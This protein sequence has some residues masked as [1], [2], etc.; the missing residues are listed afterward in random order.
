MVTDSLI[1]SHT[2]LPCFLCSIYWPFYSSESPAVFLIQ[3]LC[4]YPSLASPQILL[5]W[6]PSDLTAVYFFQKPFFGHF[7]L[8]LHNF[9]SLS[10]SLCFVR[11]STVWNYC[12]EFQFFRVYFL[13]LKWSIRT[14]MLTSI[15][16]SYTVYLWHLQECMTSSRCL[17]W[18]MASLGCRTRFAPWK[19]PKGCKGVPRNR[20]SISEKPSDRPTQRKDVSCQKW[21][22]CTLRVLT[23]PPRVWNQW[24][25]HLFSTLPHKEVTTLPKQA[26]SH[27]IHLFF[28]FFPYL[29]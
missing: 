28:H 29:Q 5:C 7:K 25:F 26:G 14:K 27:W 10:H 1:S 22:L 21:P 8:Y 15:N 3:S 17:L 23:W 13:L 24:P 4:S 9:I 20:E 19:F 18:E 6:I 12:T 11:L 16:L 2:S